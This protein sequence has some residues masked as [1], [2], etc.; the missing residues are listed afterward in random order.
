MKRTALTDAEEKVVG[1]LMDE[2]IDLYLVAIKT[3][4]GLQEPKKLGDLS[5]EVGD[6]IRDASGAL[7]DVG[8]AFLARY[9]D[10]ARQASRTRLASA[11]DDQCEIGPTYVKCQGRLY[12]RGR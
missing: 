3:A 9:K 4:F 5:R 11:Q 10:S 6:A 8:L 7:E 1:R 2:H 12:R